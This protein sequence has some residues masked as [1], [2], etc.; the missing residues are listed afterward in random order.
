MVRQGQVG[1]VYLMVRESY[2]FRLEEE[3]MMVRVEML[4]Q[5]DLLVQV[6]LRQVEVVVEQVMMVGPAVVAEVEVPLRF[7]R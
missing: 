7:M 5:V 1:L 6:L 3:E 2:N 4:M